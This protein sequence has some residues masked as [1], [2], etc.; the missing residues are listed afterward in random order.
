MRTHPA[1]AINSHCR[2]VLLAN[3]Q[4]V[5]SFNRSAIPSRPVIPESHLSSPPRGPH[6][7][8]IFVYE[9]EALVSCTGRPERSPPGWDRSVCLAD[10]EQTVLVDQHQPNRKRSGIL[11]V[12]WFTRWHLFSVN[13][14][15]SIDSRTSG[16]KLHTLV[17][18]ILVAIAISRG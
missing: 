12:F 13:Q 8:H 17:A 3:V 15:G 1:P 18:W 4:I 14:P 10:R 16:V 11:N 9:S 2:G 7:S 6:V 5:R